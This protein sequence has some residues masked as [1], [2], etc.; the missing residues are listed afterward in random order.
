MRVAPYIIHQALKW[1]VGGQ[2]FPLENDSPAGG[3]GEDDDSDHK[4]VYKTPYGPLCRTV[5]AW[6]RCFKYIRTSLYP[7][8][9]QSSAS[10]HF[11]VVGKSSYRQFGALLLR[12][13]SC[14]V[15][16]ASA[17]SSTLNNQKTYRISTIFH[18]PFPDHAMLVLTVRI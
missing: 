17:V 6:H 2:T 14:C 15:R 3:G 4:D 10:C 11:Y 16:G 8:Q 7:A 5:G 18:L 9:Q 13:S 1:G 12:S